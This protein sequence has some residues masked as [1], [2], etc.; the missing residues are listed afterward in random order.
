VA[1]RVPEAAEGEGSQ[2]GLFDRKIEGLVARLFC[3]GVKLRKL[4][5]T[6]RVVGEAEFLRLLEWQSGDLI[7]RDAGLACLDAV[8]ASC[9][10]L[11]NWVG[12]LAQSSI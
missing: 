10:R 7:F 2:V 4:R 12:G 8:M 11:P 9:S 1:S 3:A 5:R 6:S